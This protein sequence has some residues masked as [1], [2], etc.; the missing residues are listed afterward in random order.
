LGQECWLNNPFSPFVK[1]ELFAERDGL[2]LR[3][4]NDFQKPVELTEVVLSVE[5]EAN[6]LQLL[7]EPVD[8]PPAD[9]H[10]LDL[11]DHLQDSFKGRST[12]EEKV[13]RI[14]L[15]LKPTP[16]DQ[17]EEC[18]FRIAFENQ[19]FTVARLESR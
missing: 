2:K 6:P 18:S 10:Y 3:L 19:R 9:R 8:L 16:L 17:P 14:R 7:E 1:V 11:T 5:G 15:A 12:R 4:R 13:I